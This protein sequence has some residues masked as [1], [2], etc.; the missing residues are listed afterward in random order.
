M[1]AEVQVTQA[2][3]PLGE[4]CGWASTHTNHQGRRCC[5]W[6]HRPIDDGEAPIVTQ[7]AEEVAE[8]VVSSANIVTN[9]GYYEIDIDAVSAVIARFEAE[10]TQI[11][12]APLIKALDEA[13]WALK[14]MLVLASLRDDATEED[15]DIFEA[16]ARATLTRIA[17]TLAAH[18]KGSS[19]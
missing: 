2:D 11:A 1:S 14:S 18:E 17:A 9:G 3:C 12:T 10:A 15:R 6:C 7:R 5:D 19:A 8:E 4:V 16:L 13:G